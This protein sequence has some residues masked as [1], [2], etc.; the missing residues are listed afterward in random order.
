M[1]FSII[2]TIANTFATDFV[3]SVTKNAILRYFNKNKNINY[4]LNEIFTY[5]TEEDA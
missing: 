5:H 1:L 2:E 4:N 3:L